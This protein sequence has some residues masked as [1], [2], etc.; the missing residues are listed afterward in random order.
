MADLLERASAWLEDQRNKFATRQVTYQRGEQSVSV[1]ATIGKTLFELD[2]GGG[3]VLRVESRDYL[4]FA[5][6]LV[7]EDDPILPQRGDQIVETQ[8]ARSFIYEVTGPGDEPCWRYSDP[9]RRTLRIH[10]K[11]VDEVVTP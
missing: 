4:I 2:D 6:D 11:Q 7:L 1:A 10:T 3:A 5:A 9:Y 8:D